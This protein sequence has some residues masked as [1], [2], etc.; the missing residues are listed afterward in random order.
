MINRE[1]P[2]YLRRRHESVISAAAEVVDWRKS[3]G[4]DNLVGGLQAA[5]INVE[6][7]LQKEAAI[8]LLRYSGLEFVEAFQNSNDSTCVL[9][10]PSFSEFHSADFLITSRRGENP[11]RPVNNAPKSSYLPD[12]RLET[13][14]FR[15]KNLEEYVSIQKSNGVRFLSDHIIEGENFYFIQT[16]PSKFTGNSLGFIEWVEKEGNY[17]FHESVDQPWNLKKP[18]SEHLNNIRWLD[19]AATRVKAEDRNDAILEFMRLTNYNF[20][21]AYYVSSL[22]SITSVARLSDVDFAMVFTS[23]ITP[24]TAEIESGPTEKFIHNYGT[25]VHHIAF[26]TENIENTFDSLA[27]D[28]MKYLIELVGSP[29]EGLKQ[30][31]TEPSKNTLLVIEYIHRYGDFDGFFT[32]SN[33][34]LLTQATDKQ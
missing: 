2:E 11:F 8:E 10:T 23:G 21:F 34:T 18:E 28:G 22:N 29:E 19:H 14:I 32:K 16:E 27:Q 5:V 20:D 26:Q 7:H 24:F 12:T 6:P 25:R 31:F 1:V 30:T 15:T 13:F 17:R 33:T 4:L 9:K 3:S